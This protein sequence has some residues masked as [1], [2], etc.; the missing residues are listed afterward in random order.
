MDETSKNDSDLKSP[1]SVGVKRKEFEHSFKFGSS[2]F[3]E[4]KVP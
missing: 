1:T 2:I 3:S 4:E